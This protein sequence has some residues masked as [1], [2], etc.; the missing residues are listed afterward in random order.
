MGVV[1]GSTNVLEATPTITAG[2]YTS[3]DLVGGKITLTGIVVDPLTRPS[4]IIHSVVIT[5]KGKQSAD[6]DVVFFDTDPENTT[7]TDNG[8]FAP[9]DADLV[10]IVG[11]S[12]VTT[13]L[14]FNDNGVSIAQGTNIP[15]RITSADTNAIYAA[16]V[17]RGT[18]TY[19]STSDITLKVTV[20]QD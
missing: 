13:H 6:Y 1:V 3:G 10:N 8:V 9:D 2:A 20:L 11:G 12:Q 5:D 16:L 4:G 14:A 18:P 17:V 7:F 19:T 15:F